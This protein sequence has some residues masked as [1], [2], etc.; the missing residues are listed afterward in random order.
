MKK[1]LKKVYEEELPNG[2]AVILS[3][4][5]EYAELIFIPK[6]KT[7]NMNL[8]LQKSLDAIRSYL[9]SSPSRSDSRTE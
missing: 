7:I 4:G 2:K 9:L 6:D 5:P 3:S 1:K 8:L